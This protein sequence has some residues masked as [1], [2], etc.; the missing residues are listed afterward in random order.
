MKDI[1]TEAGIRTMLEVM[2]LTPSQR[3]Y[4]CFLQSKQHIVQPVGFAMQ[5]E[6]LPSILFDFQKTLV[7]WSIRRGRAA[8]FAGTGLGKTLI[9]LAWAAHMGKR[10]LIVCPLAVAQQTIEEAHSKLGITVTFCSTPQ[11]EDGIWITNYQKL[12]KFAGS[13]YD[14]IVLDE[15]S[16]LKDVDAKTRKLLI[17]EFTHIPFRLCCTATPSPNDITEIGNHAEFLGVAKR[18]EM[19]SQFFVHDSAKSANTGG[20]RIKGHAEDAFW[21]WVATWAMFVRQPSDIGGDDTL[22]QLPSLS[23]QNEIV[24]STFIP[25][26]ELFPRLVRGISGRTSARKIS[27]SDRVE[28]AASLITASDE[29]WLVWCW[30][31]EEGQRLHRELKDSVLIEGKTPEEQRI[32]NALAWQRGE[33]RVLISKASQFGKGMNWQHCHNILY[34]GLSDSFEEWFQSIRRCWRFGQ[35]HPVYVTVVT[36]KAEMIVVEN[37]KRKEQETTRLMDAVIAVNKS[38]QLEELMGTTQEKETYKIAD[39]HGGNWKLLLGDS[40]ERIK[41]IESDSVGLTI[42]SPPFATLYTYSNSDRDMG[43]SRNYGEF[44]HHMDFLVPELL[45]V[46]KSG[47]RACIH[48]QQITTTLVHHGVIG[49][50]DFRG[51]I[52]RS[53]VKHGW[54][55]DGEITVDKNPQVAA[56]RTHSKGLAFQQKE[57]DSSW[58]RPCLADYIILFRKDGENP[59]PIKSDIT[60][61]EWIEFAHPV[62]YGIKETETLNTA[63]AKDNKD[64]RHIC[65]LQLG[66]IYRCLRL[67][68]NPGDLLF[69]PFAGIGSTGYMALRHGRKSLGIELKESYFRTNAANLTSAIPQDRLL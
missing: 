41:E 52:I 35:R 46:T 64:E 25:E 62:W 1:G 6:E 10:V 18:Q 16:V 4:Q 22:F 9:Q 31:N 48:V 28:R 53:F 66:V 24:D 59:E 21:R 17:E 14:A 2:F 55:Y 26:G 68:S 34:L 7:Q 36:S 42:S 23:I 37:I 49:L 13:A 57:K 8:I 47:R 65:A 61:E 43:N 69:D 67:W 63:E 11:N 39:A 33:K 38:V 19:L 54:I 12:H 40:V 58:L 44:F 32:D 51:D 30:L 56:V 50:L 3:E 20:W 29:Q 5:K 60:N 15:S 27:L 45:R